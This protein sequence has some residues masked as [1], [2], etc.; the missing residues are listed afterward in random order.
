MLHGNRSNHKPITNPSLSNRPSANTLAR[1][2][3]TTLLRQP[4]LHTE[5]RHSRR[6]KMSRTSWSSW[7]DGINSRVASRQLVFLLDLY[8]CSLAIAFSRRFEA[9]TSMRRG[10]G[11]C[12]PWHSVARIAL[13]IFSSRDR[14]F[15][16]SAL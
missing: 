14:H 9:S 12:I 16:I 10:F 3:K 13:H 5:E 6:S 8:F 15:E 7:R 2:F 4:R 11:G 1:S